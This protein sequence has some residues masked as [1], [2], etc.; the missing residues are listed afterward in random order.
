[1]ERMTVRQALE[2]MQDDVRESH[3][4]GKISREG[5]DR[6]DTRLARVLVKLEQ[7]DN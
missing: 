6:V 2:G 3:L 7:L 5:Y 1:M 4:N